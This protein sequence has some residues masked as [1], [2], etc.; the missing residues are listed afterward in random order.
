MIPLNYLSSGRANPKKAS[1]LELP[2]DNSKV[3]AYFI[4][5]SPLAQS[6]LTPDN[7]PKRTPECPVVYWVPCKAFR[8]AAPLSAANFKS[9]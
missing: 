8:A 6:S 1:E 5:A 2:G 9:S 3:Q 4:L 7:R